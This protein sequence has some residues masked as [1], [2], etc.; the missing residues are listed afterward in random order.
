MKTAIRKTDLNKVSHQDTSA[1][2]KSNK[3]DKTK[4]AR[5][6]DLEKSKIFNRFIEASCD[7]V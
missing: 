7:C 3:S 4:E 6:L 5:L 1:V 2:I